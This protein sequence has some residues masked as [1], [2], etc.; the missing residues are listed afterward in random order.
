MLRKFIWAMFIACG[1]V[2]S[3]AA[4]AITTNTTMTSGGQ[5]IKGQTVTIV[6]QHPG[7]RTQTFTGKT[8]PTT[9]KLTV[10]G[11]P[12]KKGTLYWVSLD[13]GLTGKQVTRE[14][15]DG[16]VPI[17]YSTGV[18]PI[19]Q[20]STY[21]G[22][23]PT[24]YTPGFT[25]G[26]TP[27]VWSGYYIGGQGF[28]GTFDQRIT[29]RIT[30]TD[31]ISNRLN[32]DKG[33]GGVG[34]IT[35]WDFG[36]FGIPGVTIGPTGSF[37][38][39][40]QS[41]NQVFSGGFFLGTRTNWT[42]DL[43]GKVEY[44]GPDRLM[45]IYAVGGLELTNYDLQSNFTGPTLAVNRT[46]TGWFAGAGVEFTRP[47]WRMGNG[48]WTGFGQLTFSSFCG[49]TVRMPAFSQGFDYTTQINQVRASAGLIY[50]IGAPPPP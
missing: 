31:I 17:D 50:R 49:D 25:P 15:L 24:G 7:G 12:A 19:P 48:Q 5:P 28:G 46:A 32:N 21:T 8:H 22:N 37:N 11:V 10:T 20:P 1:V 16:G 30:G 40:G 4:W 36:G 3:G 43:G 42:A 9:G 44:W 34:I 27:Y 6:T 41:N 47:G 14:Q 35:G 45:A 18:G 23:P 2:F 26:Y 13:G 29:E 39:V 33:M 38:Y